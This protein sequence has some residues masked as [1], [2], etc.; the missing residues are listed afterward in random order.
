M[1]RED[2]EK[3]IARWSRR[4][5]DAAK[6]APAP[7]PAPPPPAAAKPELPSVETLQ[8]LASEYKDFLR[9]EVDEKLRQAALK[10]LFRDPHFNVMDGLDTY[11]D[12]YSKPDP[13]PDAMLRT[14]AHAKRL[15]FDEEEKKNDEVAEQPAPPALPE[16]HGAQELKVATPEPAEK[17]D[18]V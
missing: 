11:I 16:A 4:K 9:P 6:E 15:L 3:F 12:D 8:G 2:K 18:K 10:K 14:L 1:S 7:K 5:L 17:K 13:I